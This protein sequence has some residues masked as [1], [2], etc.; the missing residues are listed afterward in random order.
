MNNLVKFE[1][2]I[3]QLEIYYGMMSALD[4]IGDSQI[5][6]SAALSGLTESATLAAQ[7]VFIASNSRL[8]V[9]SIVA[10]ID[11][12]ICIAKFHRALLEQDEYVICAAKQLEDNLYELC[13][14]LSPKSGLLHMQ[15][16]MGASKKTYTA[17]AIKDARLIYV[18]TVLLAILFFIFVIDY[19][20]ENL[21][22][23]GS[24]L[25]IFYFII[26]FVMKNVICSLLHLSEKSEEI[27]E[28]YGFKNPKEVF[29]LP[30]RH[31]SQEHKVLL[32]GVFEYRQIIE[33]DPY[34]ES[35]LQDK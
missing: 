21:V 11:G 2:R 4:P 17:S 13:A 33:E 25:F 14:V 1:G 18:G 3:E 22:I 16:G 29:L 31:I 34:P 8:S 10:K 20:I 24:V 23:W 35:Y 28:I 7:T 9:H 5:L 27:F 30:S 32:D 15:V 6:T 26:I 12:K 19:S